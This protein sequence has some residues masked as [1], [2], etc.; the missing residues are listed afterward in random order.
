VKSRNDEKYLVN[1]ALLYTHELINYKA[2]NIC[3]EQE[4]HVVI[5]KPEF[6]IP[7]IFI[8]H[9]SMCDARNWQIQFCQ[10]CLY[11][12]NSCFRAVFPSKFGMRIFLPIIFK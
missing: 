12:L 10:L 6:V 5:S 7:M 11:L 8:L 2:F 3:F 1:T 9:G 4:M